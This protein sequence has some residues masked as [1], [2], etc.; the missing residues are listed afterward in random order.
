[1]RWFLREGW[2]ERA[3]YGTGEVTMHAARASVLLPVLAPADLAVVLHVQAPRPLVIDAAVNGRPLRS[4]AVGPESAPETMAIPAA[5]LFRGDNLLTLAARDGASGARLR[6]IAFR[7][8][9]E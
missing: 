8:L 2:G 3:N 1:M 4:W 6:G 9:A 5:A 7:P